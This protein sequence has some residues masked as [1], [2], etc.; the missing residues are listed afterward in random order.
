MGKFVEKKV[1]EER[2]LGKVNCICWHEQQPVLQR[3]TRIK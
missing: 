2:F 1:F 3:G